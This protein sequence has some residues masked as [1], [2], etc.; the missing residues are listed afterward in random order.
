MQ[1]Q[2]LTPAVITYSSLISSL[3]NACAKGAST[4]QALQLF[5]TMQMPLVTPNVITHTS[6]ISACPDLE[7]AKR[8]GEL[9]VYV[10]QRT[11]LGT[12]ITVR[13]LGGSS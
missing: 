13:M 12:P 9:Q 11:G 2:K 3:I 4:E 5:D 1:S 7:E 10:E 8:T 6:S